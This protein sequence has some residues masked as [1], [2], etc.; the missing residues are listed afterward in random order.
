VIDVQ[1]LRKRYGLTWVLR[2][3]TFQVAAGQ[4]VVILGSN[5]AGKS[6]LLRILATLSGFD[7][8]RV[9]IAEH[10]VQHSAAQVR[11]QIGYVAH[12]PLL[13]ADLTAN[14]N[15]AFF[16]RL[17]DVPRLAE[18]SAV[19]L[20]Q[21][22]LERRGDDLVRT[23]SRG[24]TQ[25]LAIARALLADPPLLLLDEPDDGLDPEAAEQLSGYLAGERTVLMVSH[26]L[27]RSLHMANR[28][29][30]LAQGH[31]AFEAPTKELSLAEL[32]RQYRQH[33]G[34]VRTR[35]GHVVAGHAS[36]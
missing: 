16:G 20:R 15:L 30:M 1:G 17:Y 12:Q 21:V 33:T 9:T 36:C 22:S 32:E 24:M 19:L 13:Y 11:R 10:D 34:T 8:G 14:E 6:T 7:G 4:F 27:A 26:N 25:R 5:G 35:D 28:I 29:L 2:D 31:V 3:I 18:R 23:F